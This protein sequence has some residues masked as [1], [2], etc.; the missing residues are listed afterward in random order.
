MKNCPMFS[1][2]SNSIELRLRSVRW[3]KFFV[4]TI[5]NLIIKTKLK[6]FKNLKIIKNTG[7]EK[8]PY[9]FATLKLY[10]ISLSLD[11]SGQ[12]LGQ[13]SREFKK[14]QKQL[15]IRFAHRAFLL[16]TLDLGSNFYMWLTLI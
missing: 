13:C 7:N 5:W 11:S 15:G 16:A 8:L 9:V 2:R 6:A 10:W 4:N 3:G 14:K 12:F 1:L